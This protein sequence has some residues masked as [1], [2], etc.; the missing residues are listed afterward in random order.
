MARGL[1][2]DAPGM[3]HH[4]TARGVDGCPIFRDDVD[5]HDMVQRFNRLV[6]ELG[7]G[8]W[9]W[10]FM[11]NHIHLLL[12]T[13]VIPLARLMARFG[14]G[15]ALYFNRRHN[16]K[17]HLW[18]DR[19]WSRPVEEDAE[20]VATY[21]H[22]NPIRAGLTTDERLPD[23]YWC[24][25]SGDVGAR[26][27]FPFERRSA[28]TAPSAPTVVAKRQPTES[29]DALIARVCE[30]RGVPVEELRAP[31]RPRA[32]TCARAEI[33]RIAVDGVGYRAADVA[34]S[35]GVDE[36]SVSRWLCRGVGA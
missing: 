31:R 10:V 36:S 22:E 3:L 5:R 18:Q 35:L 6:V 17:G 11:L 8:C 23:Y 4:V 24:G 7:F 14:T 15:Y 30:Q 34:R 20:T 9:G 29:I 12:Q 28:R 26:S 25:Y 21:I 19:Y 13:G 16:R 2:I 32:V 27:R 1:R 33:A